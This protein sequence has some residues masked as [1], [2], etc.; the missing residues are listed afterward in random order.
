MRAQ[1]NSTA[2]APNARRTTMD[3]ELL[4]PCL[5]LNAAAAVAT[6]CSVVI[7]TP[8]GRYPHALPGTTRDGAAGKARAPAHGRPSVARTLRKRAR[9]TPSSEVWFP[10]TTGPPLTALARALVIILFRPCGIRVVVTRAAPSHCVGHARP[11]VPIYCVRERACR[12]RGGTSNN[13]P[14]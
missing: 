12:V 5:L 4:R 9:V 7:H 11:R 14:R 3:N 13:T 10:R 6:G 1:F 8:P 2:S